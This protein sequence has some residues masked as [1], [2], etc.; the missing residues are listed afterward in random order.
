[1]RLHACDAIMIFVG[2]RIYNDQ[3]PQA[4]RIMADYGLSA[5]TKIRAPDV[6]YHT[7][8]DLARIAKARKCLSHFLG[9]RARA[10]IIIQKARSKYLLYL[11]RL[12]QNPIQYLDLTASSPVDQSSCLLH[13][14]SKHK[15]IIPSRSCHSCQANSSEPP[16]WRPLP[17]LHTLKMQNRTCVLD[18]CPRMCVADDMANV[19]RGDGPVDMFSYLREFVLCQS[20][21]GKPPLGP[22]QH[23]LC[24]VSGVW[25]R[26]RL[27]KRAWVLIMQFYLPRVVDFP[28]MSTAA[29]VPPHMWPSRTG[30]HS[31]PQFVRR[32]DRLCAN[33]IVS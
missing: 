18:P 4:L 16:E 10:F 22:C 30:V 9:L 2:T 21:S 32:D 25:F 29:L 5:A 19:L 15:Q 31:E 26:E 24:W 27:S 11:Q 20:R 17:D 6:D 8:F 1:M 14:R 13:P 7:P 33:C 12:S 3:L 23:A 28:L